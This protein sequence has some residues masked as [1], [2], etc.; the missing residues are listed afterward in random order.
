VGNRGWVG[1][2]EWGRWLGKHKVGTRE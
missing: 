1:V 2:G